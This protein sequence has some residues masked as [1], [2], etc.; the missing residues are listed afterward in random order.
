MAGIKHTDHAGI[1]KAPTGRG[2]RSVPSI[3][4]ADSLTIFMWSAPSSLELMIGTWGCLTRECNR[5]CGCRADWAT[6]LIS[7]GSPQAPTAV[8]GHAGTPLGASGV[9]FVAHIYLHNSIDAVNGD[10]PV[11]VSVEV[12]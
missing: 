3:R 10:G 2:D 7:L 8:A 12:S 5:N 11:S 9:L 4:Q 6:M 1:F